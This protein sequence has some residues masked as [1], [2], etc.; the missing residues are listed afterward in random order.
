MRSIVGRTVFETWTTALERGVESRNRNAAIDA[1]VIDIA[2]REVIADKLGVVRK[3]Y[4]RFDLPFTPE[5][6]ARVRA[7]AEAPRKCARAC[8]RITRASAHSSIAPYLFM[9]TSQEIIADADGRFTITLSRESA[10]GKPNHIQIGEEP[11]QTLWIRDSRADWSQIV[12]ALSVRRTA[13]PTPGPERT[14]A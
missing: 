3:V 1:K 7:E 4:Q 13:G 5:L 8:R 6:E 14:E 9:L 11:W 10:E 2:H 12:T